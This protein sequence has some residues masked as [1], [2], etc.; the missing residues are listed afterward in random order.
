MTEREILQ[1]ILRN[2]N[3]PI[4]ISLRGNVSTIEEL[5]RIGTLVERDLNEE[6]VFWRQRQGEQ[7]TFHGGR[8]PGRG[9]PNS[10]NVAVYTEVYQPPMTTLMLPLSICNRHLEAIIET[11]SSYSLIQESLWDQIKQER[12]ILSKGQTFSLANG[13]IQHAIGKASLQCIVHNQVHP[14]RVFVMRNQ[15]LTF[16][17]IFGLEF[18]SVSGMNLDFSAAFY[19]LPGE[20]ELHPFRAPTNFKHADGWS[21][22]TRL[23]IALPSVPMKG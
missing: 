9:C 17:L 1:S 21:S 13:H 3:L 15:D 10:H 6:R 23:H 16:P 4:A 20:E 12:E 18:L 5:V 14:F 22:A 19:V 8:K 2:C 11:G 7:A